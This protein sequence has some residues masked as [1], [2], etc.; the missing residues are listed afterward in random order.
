MAGRIAKSEFLFSAFLDDSTRN[1]VELFL[2]YLLVPLSLVCAIA[3]FF[4]VFDFS[5]KSDI[6]SFFYIRH[7]LEAVAEC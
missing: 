3:R 1:A 5:E 7:F 2:L 4:D 6:L